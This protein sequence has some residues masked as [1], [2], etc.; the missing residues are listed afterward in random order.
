MEV[1]S[2]TSLFPGYWYVGIHAMYFGNTFGQ[3]VTVKL[4]QSKA[5][6]APLVLD[7]RK[8][9][10]KTFTVSN[11]IPG[12]LNLQTM[13]LQMATET[14]AWTPITGTITSFD[15]TNQGYDGW[16]LIVTP[17]MTTMKVTLN[18]GGSLQMSLSLWDPA[19]RLAKVTNVNGGSIT[20]NNPA[21]GAWTAII[22]INEPGTQDYTL[23][24]GGHR[25]KAFTDVTITPDTF[26]LPPSGTQTLTIGATSTARGIGQIVYYDL[27]TLASPV[28]SVYARTLLTIKH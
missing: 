22:T 19:G 6:N 23:N 3:T 18:W 5:I 2:T 15:G 13:V 14:Y 10:S 25:F 28:G 9:T 4:D 27:G 24:V 21:I 26:T 11:N 7:L 20:V 1:L 12:A 8:E 16:Y 17:D